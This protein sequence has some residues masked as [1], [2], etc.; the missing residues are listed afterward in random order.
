MGNTPHPPAGPPPTGTHR[1]WLF[2]PRQLTTGLTAGVLAGL[3][4]ISVLLSLAA[5]IFAGP[6]AGF[7]ANGIGLAL[8]GAGMH[9][10]GVCAAQLA[11]GHGDRRAGRPG[12]RGGPARRR[13]CRDPVR[14]RHQRSHL[15]H[16]GG[17]NRRHHLR[18]RGDLCAAGPVSAWLAGALLS[19][20]GDRRLSGRDRLAARAGG[21]RRD[22]GRDRA[23]WPASPRCCS[24]SRCRCLRACSSASL[25]SSSSRRVPHVLVLPGLLLAATAL[26]YLWLA[27]AGIPL[28]RSPSAWLVAG[29]VHYAGAVAAAHAGH[30]R[31]RCSGRPSSP[32]P[33]SSE[34]RWRLA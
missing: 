24:P 14:S 25:C 5:L 22:H 31:R 3:L 21:Y 26:F 1:P 7:V 2:D 19:L 28:A 10:Y 32:R 23:I 4:D 11:A 9:E 13:P 18:H 34:P 33:G 16:R 17:C 12:A 6:L 20:L 8:I 29:A 27:V 30:A 15:R